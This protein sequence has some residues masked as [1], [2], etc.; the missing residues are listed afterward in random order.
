MKITDNEKAVIVLHNLSET[1]T[2][3]R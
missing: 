1:Q 3:A 2:G